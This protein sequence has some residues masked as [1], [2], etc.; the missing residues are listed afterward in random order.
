VNKIK[1]GIEMK[2]LYEIEKKIEKNTYIF[3][4]ID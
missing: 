2:A 4:E 3:N 1:I